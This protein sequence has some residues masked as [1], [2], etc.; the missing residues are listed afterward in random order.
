MNGKS[1]RIG[2]T[3]YSSVKP[4]TFLHPIPWIILCG[5]M[6]YIVSSRTC[7]HY[8]IPGY[9]RILR[10]ETYLIVPRLPEKVRLHLVTES[11]LSIRSKVACGVTT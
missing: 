6:L 9:L 2:S 10:G 8:S 11:Y 1:S 7:H 4:E 5:T 3:L